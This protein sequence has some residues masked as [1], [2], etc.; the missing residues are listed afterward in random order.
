MKQFTAFNQTIRIRMFLNFFSVITSAMVMPYTILYFNDLIGKG[1]ISTIIIMIG[2]ISVAGYLLGGYVT[3]SYGRKL[4]IIIGEG[5]SGAG[6]IVI[7][8][9][10]Y[11][12]AAYII[13]I[14]IVF[15]IMYFFETA[16]NPAY[17]ALI[18]DVSH[19]NERRVIYTYFMWLSSIA[20]ALGSVVGGFYFE[21]HS[22][23]LYFI[24]GL[25]SLI[26]SILTYL[27]VKE[28]SF[29]KQNNI[30]HLENVREIKR[31]IPG[32]KTYSIISIFKNRFF[33][34]LC[35]GAFLLTLLSEQIYSYLSV[36]VVE[37]YRI[38]NFSITGH[39][40]MGYLHLENTIIMTLSAGIIMRVTKKLEDKSVIIIGLILNVTGYICLSYFLQPMVLFF[41]MFLV[42]VGFLTYRPVQQTIIANSI[43]ENSRG[44]HLSVIGLAGPLGGMVS[45]LFIWLSEYVS[46]TGITFI[47]LIVGILIIINYLRVLK[48]YNAEIK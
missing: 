28:K 46:E 26:S 40:M 44:R 14:I 20:F 12:E 48:Y 15:S 38:E 22:S 21:H 17:A 8:Y 30:D 1:L 41:G 34:L 36:R 45:G 3:D 47:F 42:A 18:I 35:T 9:L 37:N 39:Q 25:T 7:S 11:V 4:I 19:E 13:P 33:L 6:F 10:D 27:F 5:I 24:M 32:Q 31:D 2:M 43:P 29:S 16:A 23:V